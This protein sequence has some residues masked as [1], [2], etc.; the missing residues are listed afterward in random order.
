MQY[1]TVHYTKPRY[2]LHYFTLHY[3]TLHYTTLY[4][5]TLH[6]IGKNIPQSSL[7]SGLPSRAIINA[8]VGLG[9][10]RLDMVP[11]CCSLPLQ[12]HLKK[13]IKNVLTRV[14]S[15]QYSHRTYILF[16]LGGP[17]LPGVTRLYKTIMIA[18]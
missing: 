12:P 13:L 7:A 5:T 16:F 3:T 1:S 15:N 9:P 2:S 8:P 17:W 6:Y 11:S 4:Y 14:T 18:L 10:S